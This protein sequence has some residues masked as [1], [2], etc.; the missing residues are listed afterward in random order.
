MTTT[1]ELEEIFIGAPTVT[2]AGSDWLF[3]T[4]LQPGYGS[5]YIEGGFPESTFTPQWLPEPEPSWLSSFSKPFVNFGQDFYKAGQGA[6]GA[7]YEKL[8]E[9]LWE[10]YVVKPKQIKIDEGAGVTV[11]HTQA[12]HAGGEPAQPIVTTIPQLIPAW[13]AAGAP[14]AIDTSTI[15]VIVAGLAAVFFLFKGK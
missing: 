5:E 4:Y 9:L 1:A 14:K 13:G 7:T 2:P 15:L 11:V 12:P 10:K 8:P 3:P 6:L